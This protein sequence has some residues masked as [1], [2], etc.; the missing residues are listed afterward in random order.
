MKYVA[1]LLLLA[2]P[3]MQ[4]Q[5]LSKV[6]AQAEQSVVAQ[7]VTGQRFTFKALTAQPSEEANSLL[8]SMYPNVNQNVIQLNGNVFYNIKI[9]PEKMEVY[10]P[11]FGRMYAPATGSNDGGYKFTSTQYEYRVEEKKG[12]YDIQIKPLDNRDINKI[13]ITVFSN[14]S[15]TVRISSNTRSPISYQGILR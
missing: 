4:A 3:D 13:F 6:N 9:S 2:S 11:Y 7:A 10:L 1:A 14:G 15:A 12:V 8:R 5:G